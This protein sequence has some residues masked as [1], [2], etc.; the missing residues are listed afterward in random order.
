MKKLLFS[1]FTASLF[2][3]CKP[4]QVFVDKPDTEKSV[5]RFETELSSMNIPIEISLT[6]MQATLNKEL[7]DMTFEDNDKFMGIDY[8]WKANLFDKIALDL[9]QDRLLYTVPTLIKAEGS[10]FGVESST[11]VKLLIKLGTK[12]EILPDWSVSSKTELINFKVVN[13]TSLRGMIERI[14]A[15]NKT[16]IERAIDEEVVGF[17]PS[18]EDLQQTWDEIQDPYLVSE[19]YSAWVIARPQAIRLS[20]LKGVNK[21][22]VTNI[23]IDTYLDI[24]IGDKPYVN[25]NP[26]LPNLENGSQGGSLFKI[27]I[28][29]QIDYKKATEVLRNNFVG[30]E[31]EYKK[32]K[33]ITIRDIEVFGNGDKIVIGMAFDGDM[34]GKIYTTGTPKYDAGDEKIYIDNFE[35]DA[36]TKNKLLN[37][38]ES[39]VKGPFKKKIQKFMTFSIRDELAETQKLIDESLKENSF[40]DKLHFNCNIIKIEPRDILMND[41]GMQIMLAIIGESKL[42]YKKK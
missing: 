23:G 25:K 26:K 34:E 28:G 42:E 30:Y 2:F 39:L 6:Q 32:R 35:F 38:A 33:K 29:T 12:L 21:H 15:A 27:A 40:D 4:T 20:S 14:V 41:E 10:L 16:Y 18:K 11:E 17:F 7:G 1:V 31:F 8:H 37:V 19:E 9:E 13:N 3:A 36:K 22:I 24:K 5:K